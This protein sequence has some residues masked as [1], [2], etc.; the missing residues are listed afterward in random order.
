MRRIWMCILFAAVILTGCGNRSSLTLKGDIENNTISA[1]STVSGKIISMN[2]N[3]GEQVK[4]G[5]IIALVDNSNQKYQVEQL[6]AVVDMKKAKL[7]ELNA[8]ARP[9]QIE[10]ARAQVKAANAQVDL[11]K[12]GNRQEQINQSQNNVSI[13]QQDLNIAQTTY[14]NS[15]S[16]YEKYLLLNKSG[17]ISQKELDDVKSKMDT[18]NYTLFSAKSK[19]D[20]AMQQLDLM[21]E[22]STSQAI[23]TASANYEAVNAQLKLLENGATGDEIKAAQEDLN[24]SVAQLNQ[25]KN[26]LDKYNI[27][28]LSDGIII[29]K[30]FQLGDIVTTG[31]NIADIAV[32]ND[33]YVICYLPDKYLDKVHYNQS[34]AVKTSLGAQ[35]GKI[36]YIDLKKEYTPKDK[37]ST[38]D[39]DHIA[40]KIKISIKDKSGVL[41]SGMTA[42]VEIPLNK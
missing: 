9:E 6:Q 34:I 19:L 1:N 18:S 37:Q 25:A 30:N 23:E 33:L 36:N 15:N 14:D 10:Q 11:L 38:S 35:K 22:G 5:D 39:E 7:S 21:K 12:S 20:N 40:T 4:K 16:D 31:S 32:K 17:A 13:A 42:E 28:A 8:G 2:K 41:K 29:S 3:Q 27:T 24:Q 26:E